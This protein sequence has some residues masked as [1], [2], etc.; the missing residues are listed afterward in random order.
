MQSPH[1][2]TIHCGRNQDLT[3]ADM[4]AQPWDHVDLSYIPMDS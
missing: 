1:Y 2:E 3:L 4:L